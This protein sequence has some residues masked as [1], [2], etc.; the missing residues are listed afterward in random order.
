MLP[1][2]R[3]VGSRPEH[4]AAWSSH[5]RIYSS[6]HIHHMCPPPLPPSDLT[7]CEG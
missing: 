1:L 5:I 4:Q 3:E 6:I 7:I 2:D